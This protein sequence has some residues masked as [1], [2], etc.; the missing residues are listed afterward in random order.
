MNMIFN[1]LLCSERSGSNF[2]VKLLNAHPKICGPSPNHLIRVIALNEKKYGN[3]DNLKNWNTLVDDVLF[4]IEAQMA[5]WKT[6]V[7]VEEILQK[8]PVG[9]L[10]SLIRFIFEKEANSHNKNELFIKEN[11]VY[12]YIEWI[13]KRFQNSNFIYLVRDVR[14]VALSWKKSP[15]HPG[16]I[17]K[18]IEVWKE[19][20]IKFLK[21]YNKLNKL[22]RGI[23]IKYENLISNPE[24]ELKKICEH[25]GI[26]YNNKMLTF[27]KDKLTIKNAI[28]IENWNNLSK[29]VIKNNYNKFKDEL[30]DWEIQYIEYHCSELMQL[31]DYE[32]ELKPISSLN[33][34]LCE[35]IEKQEN[36]YN[37]HNHQ[38]ISKKEQEVRNKRQ[39]AI[40]QILNRKL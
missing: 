29:P 11:Q 23:L 15:N 19:D 20:Q 17:K 32:F 9:D 18:A 40:K 26:D 33:K 31:F 4:Y 37:K 3:L 5:E 22:G 6:N 39:L 8:C 10:V 13:H 1:F 30:N 27:Y 35:K 21:H 2:M 24:S 16:A 36:L 34:K 12:N 28:K 7:T 38:E 25:I 14:D